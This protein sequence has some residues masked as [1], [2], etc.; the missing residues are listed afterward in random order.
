MELRHRG[1]EFVDGFSESEIAAIGEAFGVAV[2]LELALFL[3]VGV[4]VSPKWAP[5][6]NGPDV[7]AASTKAWIDRA[8]AFD[9]ERDG[10]W[11]LSFGERPEALSDAVEKATEFVASAPPLLPIYGHRFLTTEPS[12]G[13]RAVLSVWQA[14]DSIFYG[15]DLADYFAREFGTSRP[16]WATAAEPRVPVWEDLFGLF[17]GD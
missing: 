16:S 11:H 10:Y 6:T 15:N 3:S 17:G 7:V 9:I 2:P 8:L 5:W 14:A 12:D 13:S 4:P 1:V